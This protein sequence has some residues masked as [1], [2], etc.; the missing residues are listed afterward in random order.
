M[1]RCSLIRKCVIICII[2]TPYIIDNRTFQCNECGLMYSTRGDLRQH[3]TKVHRC[4][5]YAKMPAGGLSIRPRSYSA[6]LKNS[7][8]SLSTSSLSPTKQQTQR[9]ETI[10]R[11]ALCSNK[12]KHTRAIERHHYDAHH[13]DPFDVEAMKNATIQEEEDIEDDQHDEE[14]MEHMQS[15]IEQHEIHNRDEDEQMAIIQ[16]RN[17]HQSSEQSP[18]I[19][20][21]ERGFTT[22]LFL[23][24]CN[25]IFFFCIDGY[26]N[27]ET[28]DDF[29][30]NKPTPHTRQLQKARRTPSKNSLDNSFYLDA[31]ITKKELYQNSSYD[32]KEQYDDDMDVDHENEA[33]DI[34]VEDIADDDDN[35]INENDNLVFKYRSSTRKSTSF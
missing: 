18:L 9:R 23:I 22:C 8:R 15:D 30:S 32:M 31:S 35:L 24:L 16:F 12:F 25:I 6:S 19:V 20:K 3:I 28:A 21:I 26:D 1:F 29:L 13:I 17:Q 7:Q 34:F 27:F 10:Y 5:V 14:T 4:G 33:G 2:K 11:C